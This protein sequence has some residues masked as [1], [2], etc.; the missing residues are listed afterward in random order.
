MPIFLTKQEWWKGVR[1]LIFLPE[2]G[3]DRE[4][5]LRQDCAQ[6]YR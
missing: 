3:E 4:Q 1:A 5:G 2:E 6:A